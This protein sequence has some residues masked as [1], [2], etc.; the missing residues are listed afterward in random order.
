MAMRLVPE[1]ISVSCHARRPPQSRSACPS[2][3]F[4]RSDSERFARDDLRGVRS[5]CD[6][7]LSYG[8]SRMSV[9]GTQCSSH[10]PDGSLK[11]LHVA[12]DQARRN[13]PTVVGRR[14]ELPGQV[15]HIFANH[16]VAVSA[17]GDQS[18]YFS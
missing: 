14:A 4:Y 10:T 11:A 18:M 12:V 3:G 6:E 5:D 1:A 7:L 17:S 9:V 15:E 2:V 16:L 13:G 8:I